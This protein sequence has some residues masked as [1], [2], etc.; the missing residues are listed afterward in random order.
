M[1]FIRLDISSFRNLG[2]VSIDPIS[3]GFNFFYGNN[4]SGKTSILEAI[5]YLSRGR[6]FRCSL[7]SRIINKDTDK[8]S[9]F[10]QIKTPTEPVIPVGMERQRG[11]EV[12]I[13]VAGQEN[14]SFSELAALTPV[15]LL[16][17]NCYNLLEAGPVFRRKY[18]DWGA[19]YSSSNYLVIWKQFER[20]LRQRNANLRARSS[21]RELQVWT[22]ELVKNGI[23]LD[24]ARREVMLNLQ[25]IFMDTIAKLLALDNLAMRYDCGWKEEGSYQDALDQSVEQDMHLGYTQQGPH[26]ADIK[27]VLGRVPI[28]DILSRGQQKLFVCAMIM[29]QGALLQ[30]C[31]NRKPIYLVDDLPSELDKVSRSNLI[32]LLA[33][34]ETQVFLTAV[35]REILTEC[36]IKPVKMFHVE[37]GNVTEVTM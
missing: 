18:L 25:P 32:A 30:G 11:G 33:K 16:N 9:I 22:A 35:E 23:L 36:D 8:L 14:T 7:T 17:S 29:A 15:L 37:H 1:S 20:A 4:G 19:F 27:Y 2:S 12:R 10:A 21:Q 24:Q 31:N 13:R 3:S 34:Q 26:R 5:Y 6:S 28:K